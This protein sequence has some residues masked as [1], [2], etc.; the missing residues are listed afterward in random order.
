MTGSGARQ[1]C[2]FT[3]DGAWYGVEVERVQEVLVSREIVPVPLAPESVSGLIN[4]RGQIVTAFDL[5]RCL[6]LPPL[7]PGRVPVNLVIESEG[8]AVSLL[9]DEIRDVVETREATFERPP[10]TLD[11]SAR[12]MIRGAHKLDDGLLLILDTDRALE[13]APEGR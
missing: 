11:G 9:V 12:A 10:A 3:L 8:E 5:R 6:G 1:Y 4:L 2:T 7:A 13:G